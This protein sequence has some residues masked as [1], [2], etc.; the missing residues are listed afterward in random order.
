MSL[1]E[2]AK[3]FTMGLGADFVGVAPRSRFDS[4]P[5]WS[6]PARLLPGYACVVSFGIAMDRGSLEA[7][8]S[9]ASRRP[10][11]LQSK[12][13]TTELDVIAFK[14]SRWLER[15]G[16]KTTYVAQNFHYNLFRGRP[17]FSHKHAAMAAG[18]GRLGSSSLLVHPTHGAAVHLGSVI[19]EAEME[20]DPI[21]AEEDNPCVGCNICVQICPTRAMEPDRSESFVMA[22]ELYSHYRV[23]NLKCAWGCAGLTG[24][25]YKISN[26]T[27]GTWAYN[28]LEMPHSAYEFLSKFSEAD[29]RLRHPMEIAEI[30]ITNGTE[31]CGNCSKVCVGSRRGTAA[32]LKLHMRSG[33]VQIPEDPTLL[34]HLKAANESLQPHDIPDEVKELLISRYAETHK[35]PAD[36]HQQSGKAQS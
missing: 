3:E 19:T 31:F 6:D 1:A 4:A 34:Y 22:G 13:A 20:P 36:T 32:M 15:Q 2:K 28:D 9:K 33:L 10:L 35:V 8:F 21:L 7:W 12:L 27:V 5:S 18:L 11:V 24:H 25:Q 23:D 26:Q 30:L 16:H 29:R 14:L 17:D